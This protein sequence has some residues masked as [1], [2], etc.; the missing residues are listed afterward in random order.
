[1]TRLNKEGSTSVPSFHV[2]GMSVVN[3]IASSL[4]GGQHYLRRIRD[5]S[6]SAYRPHSAALPKRSL[7][8]LAYRRGPDMPDRYT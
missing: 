5:D 1:M 4:P 2:M 8:P 7:Q 3:F 6:I